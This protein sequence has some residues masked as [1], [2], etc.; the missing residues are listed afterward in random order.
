MASLL[1]EYPPSEFSATRSFM[2]AM[3]VSG[4]V[5][6]GAAVSLGAVAPESGIQLFMDPVSDVEDPWGLL[7]GSP[8]ALVVGGD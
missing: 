7:M 4:H 2:M 8:T 1:P 5:L 6:L 3:H